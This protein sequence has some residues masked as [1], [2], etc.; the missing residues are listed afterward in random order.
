VIRRLLRDPLAHFLLGGA[1]LWLLL[2]WRGEDADPASRTIAITRER[3][4][5]LAVNFEQLMGRVPTDQELDG[6]IAGDIREE[7]LYREALRLGL[8]QDDPVIRRRLS[9]KMDELAA[10]EAEGAEPSDA[11]LTTWLAAHP[12]RFATGANVSFDQAA[13]AS[14]AAARAALANGD[15]D[16]EALDLPR[17]VDAMPL[18]EVRERFGVQ[19]A[20]GIADL[21]PGTRWQGPI[22]SGLGWHIVRLSAHDPGK[23]PPLADI[24]AAIVDDWRASTMEARRAAAFKVLR[25]SYRVTVAR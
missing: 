16:G 21:K 23:I 5:A 8:D 14:E 19:F 3:E 7:V 4:A 18:A 24:R 25:D 1:V 20:E 15:A 10:A 22:P 9:K 11:D 17:H 6:L 13:F 2:A 12:D